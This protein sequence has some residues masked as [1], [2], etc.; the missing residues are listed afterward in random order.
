MVSS[1][2]SPHFNFIMHVLTHFFLLQNMDTDNVLAIFLPCKPK[3]GPLLKFI[4]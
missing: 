3:V 1:F 4:F 2:I